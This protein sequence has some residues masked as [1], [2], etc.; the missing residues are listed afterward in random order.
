[1]DENKKIQKQIRWCVAI[2]SALFI[3]SVAFG[4][5]LAIRNT[6]EVKK[7]VG[8]SLSQFAGVKE[9]NALMIFLFIFLNNAIKG[10]L[11]M[12]FGIALGIVALM[13]IFLNGELVGFVLG[14]AQF[15]KVGIVRIIVG[16]V[17]HGILEIPAIILSA[18]YGLW[19][20]YR[21]FRLI[22]MKDQ[23]KIYFSYALKKYFEVILPLFFVAALIETFVTPYVIRFFK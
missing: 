13:F 4:Y 20:G 15:S 1:M 7:I 8:D 12:A 18:G 21:F 16:I 10:F 22:W 17:P 19:L 14:L 2:V 23:F 5:V 3:F 11:I 6:Q 9:L